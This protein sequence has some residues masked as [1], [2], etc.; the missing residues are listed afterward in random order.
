MV[1]VLVCAPDGWG[2]RATDYWC[3][4]EAVWFARLARGKGAETVVLRAERCNKANYDASLPEADMVTGVG[5]GTP[6]SF[7]GFMNGVLESTPVPK[8]KYSGKIWCPVSCLV[9]R[10]LA[11]EIVEKSENAASIGEVTLYWFWVDPYAPHRGEDPRAE[12]PYLASFI[13]PEKEFRLAILEGKTLKEAHELM[14]SSYEREA[15]EWERKGYR[16]IADTLRYDAAN[17]KRFGSDDWR[18]R[19]VPPPP[20]PPPPPECDYSCG[21]CGYKA[22]DAKEL[23]LHVHEKH[24]KVIELHLCPFCGYKAA[25][26][27]ELKKHILAA[28]LQPCR[29]REWLRKR[30]G[31]PIEKLK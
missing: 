4:Y 25:D 13:E 17:R 29:L 3:P 24:P 26:E 27:E 1:K 7:H 6:T 23:T 14:L 15:K 10:A 12:D 2:D 5:H 31:C 30:F 11:P 9:G 22:E 21:F 28:H 18:I 19:E 20:P 16:E 8:G